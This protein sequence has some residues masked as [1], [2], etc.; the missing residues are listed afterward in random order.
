M[1]TKIEWTD[2]VW[3]CVTGCD[4]VSQGCKNCYAGRLAETRLKHLAEYKDGF[5]GNV[6]IHPDRL[7]RPLKWNKPRMIFVNS[8]SDLFHPDAPFE[9]IAAAFGIMAACPQH[10]FQILTKRPEKALE[11]FE[12]VRNQGHAMDIPFIISKNMP[13]DIGIDDWPLPNVWLGVSVENQQTAD[14][15][16]P[17][18]LKCPAAIRFV[19]AEPLLGPIDFSPYL[20]YNIQTGGEYEK[21]RNPI[22]IDRE[23][24]LANNKGLGYSEQKGEKCSAQNTARLLSSKENDKSGEDTCGSTQINLESN[25]WDNTRRNDNQSFEWDKRRQ[26]NRESGSYDLFGKPDSCFEDIEGGNLY[27]SKRGKQLRS[28]AARQSGKTNKGDEKR[29]ENIKGNSE[30]IRCSIPNNKQNLSVGAKINQII[31]GGE[32]GPKARPMN[33]DWVRSIRDQ[34]QEAGVPFFFKQWGEWVGFKRNYS[35]HAH[36]YIDPRLAFP[37]NEKY[38]LPDGDLMDAH[39]SSHAYIRLGKIEAGRLLDGRDW[40]EMPGRMS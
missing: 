7:S 12:W 26:Q 19:S 17:L 5:F 22:P 28:E 30:D 21:R 23:W 31:V 15:R 13:V 37:Q 35:T 32:S 27:K 39:D 38:S 36:K 25:Q 34:C 14:E 20:D 8:M 18:L 33:P 10:T 3:N 16:I 9:F 24:G 1:G 2:E 6:Q 4:K 11:W 40:N 29:G